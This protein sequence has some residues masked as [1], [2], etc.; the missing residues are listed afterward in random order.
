MLRPR[1]TT[2]HSSTL[3]VHTSLHAHLK[4]TLACP[5]SHPLLM[6]F[7]FDHT[8]SAVHTIFSLPLNIAAAA[9]ESPPPIPL[10]PLLPTSL[11]LPPSPTRRPKRHEHSAPS[12][13][14]RP[15][16]VDSCS[17]VA[18]SC[19]G[20]KNRSGDLAGHSPPP[21]DVVTWRT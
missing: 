13:P 7:F 11:T 14:S 20:G 1:Y 12:F 17:L 2:V 9:T 18:R 21:P 8:R 15:Q 3:L 19:C 4:H 6:F 5:H 16:V 10:P